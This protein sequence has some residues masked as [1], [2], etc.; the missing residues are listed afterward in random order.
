MTVTFEKE[1]IDDVPYEAASVFDVDNDGTLDLVCGPNWY[2]GPDFETRH[3]MCELT[4]VYEERLA[5]Y[6]HDDFSAYPLDVNGDGYLDVIT[7]GWWGKTLRWRENPGDTGDWIVREEDKCGNVETI[8]FFDI[9]GC[10]TVEIFPNT[11]NDPQVFYKLTGRPDHRF[12]KFT[13]G[14]EPTDD[15]TDWSSDVSHGMGFGDI[16][17][18]GRTDVILCNGWL[19]CPDDPLQNQWSFHQEFDFGW[20]SVP[21]LAHDITGDGKTDLIVGQA[22]DYGLSWWEQNEDSDGT[23]QWEEHVIDPDRS[24]YHD[25]RLVDLNN[26]GE[27][28]LVT[29]K[30]YLAH[31]GDDPGSGD[32]PFVC[33]FDIDGGSFNRHW[34]DEPSQEASGVGI[35]FWMDDITGNG[36]PDLVAPG[37]D[38]LF[39]FRNLG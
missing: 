34:I 23:R 29:G 27:L 33:Y 12:E 5:G 8:R 15:D 21:I 10:G 32:D 26:D 6:Y 31:C 4:Q 38:G 7:G 9:D 20:A 35:Y 1:L 30:R 14:P 25:L 11:P 19:E 24:Q 18:N 17:G 13:I 37:K 3:K 22:H 28:E 2:E 39:L 16:N 36:Y